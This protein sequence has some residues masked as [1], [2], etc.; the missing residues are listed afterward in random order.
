MKRECYTLC[1]TECQTEQALC[2]FGGRAAKLEGIISARGRDTR[3]RVG[4][5][6]RLVS[7]SSER[8]RR[9]IWRVGFDQ[10]PVARHEAEQLGVSPLFERHD[11]AER[12]VPT[13]GDGVLCQR[14]RPGVAVQDADYAGRLR[15][16]D[17]RTRVILRLPSVHHDRLLRLR[18]QTYLGGK[19]GALSLARRVVVVVVEAALTYRDRGSQQLAQP[20]NVAPLIESGCVVRMDSR[21][22]EDIAGKLGRVFGRE[23]RCLQRLSYT[24]DSRR[25]RIAG[26]RDYRV[27]VAGERRVGEVGMA[28]DEDVRTPPVLRGHLRSIQRSTGAAM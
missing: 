26:A 17:E 2:V 13:R 22:R 7:L 3:E 12:H 4:D 1:C 25:A 8:D 21:G 24:D 9:Q 18:G 14:V 19:G 23:R 11:S 20:R 6:G 10:Q 15:F 27:A 16:G 28:V 5:P